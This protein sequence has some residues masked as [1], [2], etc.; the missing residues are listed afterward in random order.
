MNF[1][2]VPFDMHSNLLDRRSGHPAGWIPIFALGICVIPR[3]K[4]EYVI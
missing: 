2:F 1:E 4:L 3:V